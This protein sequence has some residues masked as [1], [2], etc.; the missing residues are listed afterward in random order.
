[1]NTRSLAQVPARATPAVAPTNRKN[2]LSRTAA[3]ETNVTHH[4]VSTMSSVRFG[5]IRSTTK[6]QTNPPMMAATVTAMRT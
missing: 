4:S 1:M 5:P 2:V 3:A 6:P